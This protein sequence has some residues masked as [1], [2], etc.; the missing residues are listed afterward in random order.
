MAAARGDVLKAQAMADELPAERW[1]AEVRLRVAQYRGNHSVIRKAA[2]ELVSFGPDAAGRV[3][4]ADG[5]LRAGDAHGETILTGVAYD[6]NAPLRD[7]SAAFHL[8]LK[9]LAGRDDWTA[10]DRHWRVWRD[11]LTAASRADDRL[12]AWQVR[13]L[14]HGGGR[15]D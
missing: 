13:V 4:A 8:L 3:L 5:L 10:V 15:D 9:E 7:R 12:S 2:Q 1:A 14:H 6:P 11:A